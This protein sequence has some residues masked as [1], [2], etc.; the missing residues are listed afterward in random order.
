MKRRKPLE[1]LILTVRDQKV[2]LDA[3]LA[4][5]YGVRTKALNQAVKR[6]PDRFPEDFIFQLNVQEKQ[7]VVTN[8]DHLSRLKFSPQL[9]LAFTEHGALQAANVLKSKR[10]VAMSVY[11]IRAFIQMR[12]QIAA[13]SAIQKRL[14]EIDRKLLD[15]D[16]ALVILWNQLKPL[17]APPRPPSPRRRIGFHPSEGCVERVSEQAL[18]QPTMGSPKSVGTQ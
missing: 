14:G 6:N 4:D 7:E 5:I 16:E 13:N 18:D 8:C 9:P 15:H 3:D 2:I 17:L 10:A 12:E 1:A 11:V